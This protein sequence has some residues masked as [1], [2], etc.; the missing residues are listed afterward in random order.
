MDFLDSVSHVV[1][2]Y[3]DAQQEINRS[4]DKTIEA[5][6]GAATG[7]GIAVGSAALTG[8]GSLAGYAGMASAVSSRQRNQMKKYLPIGVAAASL[9]IGLP[10]KA[11][12]LSMGGTSN[13]VL[14]WNNAALQA[15][16]N[17]KFAPP[18]TSRALAMM[19]TSIFDAWAQFDSVAVGTQLGDSYQRSHE[20]NT[21]ANKNEAISYAAYN[22]LVNLFPTQ[23][24]SFDGVMTRLGYNPTNS[25]I[26]A[27]SAAG[28]GNLA[29]QA[30]L[31]FRQ[32]DGSNQSGSLNASGKAYSQPLLNPNYVAYQ[33]VNTVDNLNSIDHWQPQRNAD[34]TA[35]Q[36][37]VPHWGS[38][39]SFALESGSEFRPTQGPKTMESDPQG[40]KAQAK[41]VYELSKNLTDEQKLIANYWAAGGGTVTPPGMWNQIAQDISKKNNHSLDDDVKMFFA[42]DNAVFDSSIAAW[43]AKTAFD[44]ARPVTVINY[45]IDEDWT[46]SLATPPFAEYVSGHSTFSS[47]SA[48]ILKRFT[49]SDNYGGSYTKDGIT[50]SWNT[51][52]DAA[53]EA[54]MSRLYGGIHFM[55]GNLEGQKV[56]RNVAQK[57]WDKVQ[58][59][60]SGLVNGGTIACTAPSDYSQK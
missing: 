39:T 50:L 38:V 22:T 12:D 54:G 16:Q 47:S 13:H 59:F 48:E 37:L 14:E 58:G 51:F 36:F 26:D 24:S 18:M 55:D 31:N 27:S 44:S 32:K 28:I 17:T 30:V 29:A 19:H 49:G 1:D 6:A 33:P 9:L 56:G 57:V 8:A 3:S 2:G 23:V 41:E 35:Q 42:L 52:T 11:T 10:A 46:P 4:V 60:F 45:L 53:Q 25:S 15:V 7:V 21:L 34:G 5:G 40:F 20:E 43:D